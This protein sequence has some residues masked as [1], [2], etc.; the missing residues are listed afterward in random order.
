MEHTLFL[1]KLS[2]ICDWEY[3]AENDEPPINIRVVKIKHIN[4]NNYECCSHCAVKFTS[5]QPVNLIWS[6]RRKQ[7]IH[8]CSN[9]KMIKDNL[10][11]IY[12]VNPRGRRLIDY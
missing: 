5:E 10:T 7:W 12:D 8:K 4:I 3:Y 2:E 1:T 6:K 9:C 11:G